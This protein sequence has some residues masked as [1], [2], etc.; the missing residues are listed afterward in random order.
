MTGYFYFQKTDKRAMPDFNVFFKYHASY[1]WYSDCIWFLTQMR[2]WGQIP[3]A[4]P[5]AWFHETAKSIYR[6]DIYRAAAAH[7]I[8][9]GHLEA[10]E[11][12]ASDTDG[13][14]PP[15]TEF[16]DGNRYDGRKPVEYINSF[17][18]GLKD[19]S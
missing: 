1:P 16:I 15:T 17:A 5:D 11:I 8:E 9:E 2:R 10:A 18:I 19:R 7:L 4:K 13:Y 14:R 12:P 3:E 6:P